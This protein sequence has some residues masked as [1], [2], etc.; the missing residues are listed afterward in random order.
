MCRVAFSESVRKHVERR[1]HVCNIRSAGPVCA[2][3]LSH[4]VVSGCFR[5]VCT[6]ALRK[7]TWLD[8]LVLNLKR[9]GV[10]Q[11]QDLG[12]KLHGLRNALPTTTIHSDDDVFDHDEYYDSSSDDS[13]SEAGDEDGEDSDD[14]PP[15]DELVQ[16]PP[17]DGGAL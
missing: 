3:K 16:A 1:V 8:S 9:N 5:C 10:D 12:G 6:E 13:A 7:V 2:N 4:G 15:A 11:E 17:G 14:N